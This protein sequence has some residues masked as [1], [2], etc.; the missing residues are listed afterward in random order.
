MVSS[1]IFRQKARYGMEVFAVSATI[2]RGSV[3]GAYGRRAAGLCRF[4]YRQAVKDKGNGVF[5][6]LIGGQADD[7]MAS[8]S[9][10]G[11]IRGDLGVCDEIFP[12]VYRVDSDGSHCG[13]RDSEHVLSRPGDET[14]SARNGVRGLD[15]SG[16]GR[17]DSLRRSFFPR[18]VHLSPSGLRFADRRRDYRA[19]T[20]GETRLNRVGSHDPAPIRKG[21]S[22]PLFLR[23]G[24]RLSGG[25]TVR[26]VIFFHHC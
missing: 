15:R 24:N 5:C 12:G 7:S 8:S 14:D 6:C 10:R 13:R 16:N 17:N 18:T 3:S 4:L 9:A 20:P 1:A 11:I 23:R 22:E 2:G 25:G 26:I 21:A 19:E